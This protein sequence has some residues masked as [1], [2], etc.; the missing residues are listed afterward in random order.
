MIGAGRR[1]DVKGWATGG[2]AVATLAFLLLPQLIL[3]IESFT[4]DSFLAFPPKRYGLRWY[5]LIL[6]DQDWLQSIKLSLIVAAITTPVTLLLGLA[7]AYGLDRG[8]Q[9]GRRL[10]F[11][12]LV[13]PMVLP[14]VVL[15]L[16]QFQVAFWTH[17]Q[18]T[19]PAYVLAHITIALPYA[20][21]TTGASLQV[22]DRR[23]EEAAL[24]L[25]ATPWRSIW[26]VLLPAIRPGLV[27][28][29]IFT[30]ITSFDEFIITYFLSTRRVTV[31]IQIF[32]SLSF[33]LDPSIAAIS[34][35]TLMLTVGLTGILIA[36]GQIVGGGG[37]VL[38]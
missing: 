23:L 9:R 12:L 2:I 30:F 28:A 16:G 1:E 36:R 17:M 20:I 8:P 32:N 4:A 7:A 26:H 18:D 24:N 14:H 31:P 29:G 37:R 34:G 35:L 38:R 27:A 6:S 15:G 19:V 10:I 3:L 21:I 11:T 33:Q 25:G 13:A 5:G 22:F